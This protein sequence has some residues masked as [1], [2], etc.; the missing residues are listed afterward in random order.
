MF[1]E[2][3]NDA[4][5]FFFQVWDKMS[6]QVRLEP[7]ELVISD[8]IKIHP[9]Y[10][11]VLRS[12]DLE[13]SVGSNGDDGAKNPFLHMGLHIA[14]VEQLQTDRPSGIRSV[15]QELVSKYGKDVHRAEHSA[16]SCLAEVLRV[17]T[18]D[19]HAPDEQEYLKSIRKLI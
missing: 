12:K 8:I 14:L 16:M 15:F 4:R 10:H 5:Q 2:D 13:F 18:A 9:E 7:L 6:Q 3:K 19:G 17:A 1:V 11:E